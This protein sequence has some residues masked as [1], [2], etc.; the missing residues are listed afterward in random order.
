[1]QA[2]VLHGIW[3]EGVLKEKIE[4]GFLLALVADIEMV[5]KISISVIRLL[6]QS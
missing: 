4:S 2:S 6:E 1:M 3:P 5:A